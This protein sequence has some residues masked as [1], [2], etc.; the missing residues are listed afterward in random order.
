MKSDI[1]KLD[2][3]KRRIDAI[4]GARDVRAIERYLEGHCELQELNGGDISE[5]IMRASAWP[6][7]ELIFAESRDFIKIRHE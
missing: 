2:R 6:I 5:Q 1:T 4:E 3:K 7:C